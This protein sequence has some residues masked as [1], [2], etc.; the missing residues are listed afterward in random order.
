MKSRKMLKKK[1]NRLLKGEGYKKGGEE[2][3]NETGEKARAE[4]KSR[5]EERTGW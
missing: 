1:K 2:Y 4:G 5:S 3:I